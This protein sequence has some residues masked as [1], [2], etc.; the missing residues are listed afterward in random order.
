[1]YAA[2]PHNTVIKLSYA[3]FCKI[4]R[5]EDY[6]QAGGRGRVVVD[7]IHTIY[8]PSPHLTCGGPEKKYRTQPSIRLARVREKRVKMEAIQ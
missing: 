6:V 4:R 1:M 8:R 3:P 5:E 7:L 2:L